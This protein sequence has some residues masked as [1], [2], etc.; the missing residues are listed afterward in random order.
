MKNWIKSQ[1]NKLPHV[2]TLYQENKKWKRFSRVPPGHFYS[3]IVNV[4]QIKKK[5]D[6]I[7]DK[8]IIKLEGIS[9]FID[10]QKSLL[11]EFSNYYHDIP[12][13]DNKIEGLRYYY[14]N[15]FY[16]YTDAIVLYSFM[17]HFKPKKIIE[18]GSG[19]SSAIM[20]DVNEMFFNNKIDLN[21]IEPFPKRLYSLMKNEDKK[22]HTVIEEN[23]QDVSLEVFKSLNEGDVLFI[24]STHIA[25]TGS[26]VNY[27]LFSILPIL[28]KG[29]LIH[30]HDIFF[31][32]E[33]PKKWVYDGRNWNETY[34]V[35]AFLM[36][37]T[38]FKIKLFSHYIHDFHKESFNKMPL[39]Y[40]N[41]GGNLWIEKVN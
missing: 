39:S 5:E 14:N 17:R 6:I 15:T 11:N 34:F 21:F 27:I 8:Q 18:L 36:Y 35:R 2:R 28:K 4:T 26:D 10:E 33:Y 9:L 37:N 12:F 23:A 22:L 30:V 24:D 40:K 29:V 41:T 32:F 38:S 1:I 3:P 19:F 31:P 25:K 16:S 13:Q 20:M 7:W